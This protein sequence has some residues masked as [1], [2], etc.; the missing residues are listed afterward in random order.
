MSKYSI[1]KLPAEVLS[2]TAVKLRELRKKSGF[3]QVELAERSGV[4]LGSIK[5]FESSGKISLESFV[6]LLH[7]LN[8]LDEFDEILK[9]GDNMKEIEKLFTH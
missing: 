6:K 8:R 4:S 9:P 1:V 3:T 7:L 5:R 2:N